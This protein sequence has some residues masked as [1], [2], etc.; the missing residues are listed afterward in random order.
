MDLRAAIGLYLDHART[1]YAGSRELLNMRRALDL[2]SER[3]EITDASQLDAKTLKSVRTALI[4]DG[5]SRGYINQLVSKIRRVWAWLESENIVDRGTAEH[6]RTIQPLRRGRT[7]ARETEAVQPVPVRDVRATVAELAQPYRAIVLVMLYTGARVSEVLV[8]RPA[9]IDRSDEVWWYTPGRHKT[10]WRGQSR[11]IPIDERGQAV[12]IDHLP[13][14]TPDD[15][16]FPAEGR[17]RPVSPS[18]VYH[19]IRRACERAGVEPWHPHQIRHAVATEAHEA[20]AD[21]DAVRAL[22][23]H[24]SV[25]TTERYVRRTNERAA[26][27]L[28]AIRRKEVDGMRNYRCPGYRKSGLTTRRTR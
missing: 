12:L 24:R 2:L 6:L 22:L 5:L 20:G 17:R 15:Y 14:F 13:V 9:D 25:T 3:A 11:L 18:A 23:D 4:E 27:A 8:M 10:A 16:V 19:A 1:Y 21:L 28:E 26:E 7:A